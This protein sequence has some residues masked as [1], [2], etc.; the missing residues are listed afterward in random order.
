MV[1]D[2]NYML[3]I[4]AV[5]MNREFQPITAS[6]LES[7]A[8]DVVPVEARGADRTDWWG[9]LSGCK[10]ERPFSVDENVSGT[11]FKYD[12][13]DPV[14]KALADRLAVLVDSQIEEGAFLRSVLVD[15]E[16]EWSATGVNTPDEMMQGDPFV[17]AVQGF[18]FDACN[19]MKMLARQVPWILNPE[20]GFSY[21][22]IPLV[23]VRPTLILESGKVPAV[24][25]GFGRV[26]LTD[27]HRI[28]AKLP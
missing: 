5:G 23:D 4:P 13:N 1:W 12:A 7:L 9:A 11:Q 8:N 20:M 21:T 25:D 28:A 22:F 27:P 3:A 2:T 10:F 16:S 15:A 26:F 18:S 14:A 6:F 19:Q 24:M 17:F